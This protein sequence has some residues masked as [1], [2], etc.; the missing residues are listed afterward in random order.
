M[1]S[2]FG[3]IEVGTVRYD[4]VIVIHIVGVVTKRQ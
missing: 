2:G 1:K 4:H 3:W